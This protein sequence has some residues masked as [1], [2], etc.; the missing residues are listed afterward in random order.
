MEMWWRLKAVARRISTRSL[1]QEQAKR[2]S[3]SSAV[4]YAMDVNGIL[5]LLP[6]KAQH[7]RPCPLDADCCCCST[8]VLGGGV[9]NHTHHVPYTSKMSLILLPHMMSWK[10]LVACSWWWL[11]VETRRATAFNCHHIAI[12]MFHCHNISSIYT[13]I[14]VY[15]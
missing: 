15:I 7:C 1:H 13:C 3:S 8:S 10:L 5:C 9:V 12:Y 11:C 4:E 2:A 6:V 14:N